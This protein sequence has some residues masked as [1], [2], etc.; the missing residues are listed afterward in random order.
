MKPRENA[1]NAEH[2]P[3][4]LTPPSPLHLME[5]RGRGIF[6]PFVFSCGKRLSCSSCDS[7]LKTNG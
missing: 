5:R 4:H 6:A 1:G 2:E 3:P 7:W